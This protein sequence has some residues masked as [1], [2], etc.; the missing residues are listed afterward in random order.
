[1]SPLGK[2]TLALIGL[3]CFGAA[4]FFIGMWLGHMLIDRTLVIKA[5]ERYLNMAD[6][7]I[8][9]MLP[10]RF[11][12][13]YNRIDGNFWG[14]IWGSITGS[15][16][17]GLNGFILFFIVGH[18]VFD[19]PNSRHARAF[20]KK[21]DEL[22]DRNW[23][24]IGGAIIGFVCQSRILLFAGVIIGFFGD[25]YRLENANLFPFQKIKRFWY[26]INPLKLWRHSKEARHSAFIQ[27]MAGLAAKIAKA[28]GA[29]SENEIRTFKRLFALEE[30]ESSNAA[31]I[32]NQA[33]KTVKGYERYSEQLYRLTKDNLELK[34]SALDSLFKVAAADGAPGNE[35]LE[36]LRKVARIIELPE[37]NFAVIEEIYRPKAKGSSLQDFYDI[38]GVMVNASDCEIKRRWKE[39]I[40]RYHPDRLQANGAGAEEI[41]AAT[42][43]MAEINNAYQT[44][45]KARSI[46]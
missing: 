3:R 7:N 41:E 22:W 36:I 10:Y 23:C 30:L 11:Y 33:K 19:T 1:M 29:V 12:R 35:E 20:R 18:F 27:A 45:M 37:G 8:R 2:L 46:V 38:L 34:E 39:L 9:L 42:N 43:K 31:R 13:Y 24:K 14:K 15:V 26:R 6:D 17:W 4:G 44:I 32:F 21:F 40:V 5:L 28:D 25:Y 16:L